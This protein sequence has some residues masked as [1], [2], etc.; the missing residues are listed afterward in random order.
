[1]LA[2]GGGY[3]G[4]NISI[5][6]NLSMTVLQL[7]AVR[8][9]LEH[10]FA[11]FCRVQAF[12]LVRLNSFN[13]GADGDVRWTMLALALHAFRAASSFAQRQL[14]RWARGVLHRAWQG[15]CFAGHQ[16]HADSMVAAGGRSARS[17]SKRHFQETGDPHD[18]A[19][20]L[21]CRLRPA[22]NQP[23]CDQDRSPVEDGSARL[24][25]GTGDAAGLA[26]GTIALY[27]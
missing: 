18:Y 20:W 16:R 15:A 19:V 25:Q 1:M 26:Q 8:R 5:E 4:D 22:R 2:A 12:L 10:G 13:C 3:T 14:T 23:V 11:P 7:P 27:R 24:P 17:S 21:W 9:G 6:E